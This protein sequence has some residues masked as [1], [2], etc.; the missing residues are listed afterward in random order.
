LAEAAHPDVIV[1]GGGVLGQAC[2][3]ELARAGLDVALVYPRGHGRD[4]ATLAAGAMIGAFGELT[5]TRADARED[6]KL[7]FRVRAQDLQREWIAGLREASGRAIHATDG[8][9]MVANDGGRED[10]ANL[11]WI[12]SRLDDYGRRCEWVDP[13][14]VPGLAPREGFRTHEALFIHDDLSVDSEELMQALAAALAATG[15]CRVVDDVA[16]AVEPGEGGRWRV[17]TARTGSLQ[18]PHVVVAAGARVPQALGEETL[19]RLRLPTLYFAKGIGCVMN[20]APELPHA[21]RTPNRSDACGLH[22]VPRARGRLYMGASNHYGY[23]TAAARGITPGEVSA[24]LGDSLRELN[25]AIRDATVEHFRF[26]LRPLAMDERPLVGPT[27]LPGLHLATGTFRTGIVMAPLIARVVAA[28]VAGLPSPVE[29]PFHAR[30]GREPA[31]LGPDGS[32]F[33]AAL[34]HAD[35]GLEA[36]ERGRATGD[37]ACWEQA[38]AAWETYRRIAGDLADSRI[39]ALLEALPLAGAAA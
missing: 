39:I 16:A 18:A 25:H 8:L 26:G 37:P 14:E 38:A 29:N 21:I 2:A 28:A 23:A 31:P 12:R 4:S 22:L 6:E 32:D 33:N 34:L 9:F 35:R 11:R 30:E 7:A 17:R 3:L 1:V 13:A 20:G 36:Y 19:T 27:R 10:V 24:I 5:H 15:R